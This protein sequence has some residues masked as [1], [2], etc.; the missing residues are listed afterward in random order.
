MRR[1][2]KDKRKHKLTGSV[3]GCVCKDKPAYVCAYACAMPGLHVH[4]H[5]AI[6]TQA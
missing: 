4:R 2:D 6:L 5:D 3:Y 1:K